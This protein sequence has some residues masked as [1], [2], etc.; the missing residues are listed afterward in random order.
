MKPGNKG[1]KKVGFASADGASAGTRRPSPEGPSA[2]A[3]GKK[4]KK[5]PTHFLGIDLGTTFTVAAFALRNG[6]YKVLKLSQDGNQ[7]RSAV[8]FRDDN[9]LLVGQEAVNHARRSPEDALRL[10]VMSKSML[11]VRYDADVAARHNA[12][13]GGQVGPEEDVEHATFVFGPGRH[14]PE[15]VAVELLNVVVQ[16]LKENFQDSV[17]KLG[18]VA[19]DDGFEGIPCVITVPA[20][21][22]PAQR[23][24]VKLAAKRAGLNCEYLLNEPTAAAVCSGILAML[25]SMEIDAQKFVLVCDLGGG[26]IDNTILK[27]NYVPDDDDNEK[28]E[29]VFAPKASTG[30]RVGGEHITMRLA[31][32]IMMQCSMSS[33][34]LAPLT[35]MEKADLLAAA[36]QA[37]RAL[38]NEPSTSDMTSYQKVTVGGQVYNV[39]V[40]V[41][42]VTEAARRK[43]QMNTEAA[44]RKEHQKNK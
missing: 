28:F 20:Y 2:A 6:Q 17:D 3:A 23:C 30:K 24:A 15:E 10:A 31:A 12:T 26:T 34:R 37:K 42:M 27:V 36:E 25:L 33:M 18:V 41:Q 9:T 8:L 5:Q 21:F 38:G 4:T 14:Y 22:D 35:A 43:E 44:R 32:A 7:L 19:D 13:Q 1:A 11:G 29:M 39:D 16:K 40:T